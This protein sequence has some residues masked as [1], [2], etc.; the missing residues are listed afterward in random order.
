MQHRL[1]VRTDKVP[2]SLLGDVLPLLLQE[3]SEL[4]HI[5]RHWVLL[6]LATTRCPTI[7]RSHIWRVGGR[8]SVMT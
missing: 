5:N 4:V 8:K 1:T 6:F 7:D 2:E 3:I